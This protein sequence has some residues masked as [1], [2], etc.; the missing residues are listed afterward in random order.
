VSDAGCDA[1]Y[2]FHDL[3][4]AIRKI[5][6]DLGIPIEFERGLGIDAAHVGNGNRHGAI[7]TIRYSVVDGHGVDGLLIY[8]KATLSGDEP[9][10]VANY[11]AVHAEF[12]HET[13]ANQWFGE[14]QF[15]SYRMLGVH[16][17][18]M[19][20]GDYDGRAGLPGLV[21][22]MSVR[23]GDPAKPDGTAIWR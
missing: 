10:D 3:G 9:V 4:N 7:G 16:S 18:N 23:P 11:A 21:A 6:I 1:A 15:E 22:V 20:A 8:I 14:A 12:P 13:T 19:I 17:V 2:A 5:R